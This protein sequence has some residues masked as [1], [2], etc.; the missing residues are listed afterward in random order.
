MV[1]QCTAKEWLILEET[2]FFAPLGRTKTTA[3]SIITLQYDVSIAM[4]FA[5]PDMNTTVKLQTRMN[6]IA[7]LVGY[8]GKERYMTSA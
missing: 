6:I 5:G 2:A 3:G 8:G 7:K 4:T 1:T